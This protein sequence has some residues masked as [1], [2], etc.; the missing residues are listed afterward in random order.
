MH[1]LPSSWKR[2]LSGELAKPYFKQ[3]AE[4]VCEERR[5]YKVLP[6]E[7]NTYAALDLTPY[8]KVNV[9]LLG[10]DPYP[11]PGHAHG[12]CFS[13]LPGVKPPASLANMY[14][15]LHSDLGVKVPNTGYLGPWA[16]Q[17]VLLLNAVLTVRAGVP[18]S[19]KDKGW[20]HF[21]DK[22]IEKVN[23]KT[24]HVAFILWG[25]YAQK[26]LRLIDTKR[27]TVIKGAHPSPLSAHR[28]FFGS[29]PFSAINAA[30]KSHGKPEIDWAL[31]DRDE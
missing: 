26:K 24:D 20:E 17:G 30:L 25:S 13:V 16:E 4:F 19:H 10:Q 9:L 11:T 2:E 22:I 7:E 6:A 28:G 23:E 15:E 5:R 18:N 21:T 3:L 1:D 14:K 31:P 29:R 8:A 27:H 12:L